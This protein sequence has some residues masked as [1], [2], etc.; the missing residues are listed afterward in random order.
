MA[1]A[2]DTLKPYQ[3]TIR[4]RISTALL[5]DAPASSVRG[6]FVKGLMGDTGLSA[7]GLG[8]VDLLPFLQAD[9]AG[10]QMA[11]K[12]QRAA[13]AG[14]LALSI[15][16]IPTVANKLVKPVAKKAAKGV[17][18]LIGDVVGEAAPSVSKIADAMEGAAPIKATTPLDAIMDRAK[19]QGVDLYVSQGNDGLRLSKIVVPKDQRGQGVG[20]AV[21]GDLLDYADTTGQRVTLTPSDAFGGSVPR[22]KKFYG[23]HDFTPNAGR[24]RD[25]STQDTMIRNP[26]PK[27]PIP[28][29][30]VQPKITAYH[31]SPHDFDQFSLDKVGTGEGAQAYGHGL[32]F[33]ENEAVA[34]GYRDQ[35]SGDGLVRP[36]GTVWKPSGLRHMNVRVEANRN[37]ADLDATI[38]KAQSLLPNAPPATRPLLE[39]DIAELMELR[40]S[41]GVKAN[42]GSMYQVGIDADPEHFL[43]W[44]K[45]L[46]EQSDAYRQRLDAALKHGDTSIDEIAGVARFDED[47]G[48]LTGETIYDSLGR[49]LESPEAATSA[50]QRGGI[51]GIKYL[52]QGSRNAGGWHITPPSETVSGKWMVKGSDYNSKGLQFDTE[53]EAKAALAEKIGGQTRNF[54]VFDEKLITILKKY[55]WVP[56]AALPAAAIA[57]YTKENGSPPPTVPMV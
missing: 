46:S 36:D 34:K 27:A 35:I 8:I 17:A 25:F 49:F 29:P 11:T 51:P 26:K 48:K 44:E 28:V 9:E 2:P 21:M 16:P 52:D 10:R 38:A 40:D 22:L 37:G 6:R 3:P 53:A 12:G 4:N 31:G 13:G 39:A 19:A 54:V 7:T 47:A 33:A 30:V 23:A 15:V 1:R 24:T 45:P 20:S 57:E 43:D 55:G 41:G 18:R 56:G 5:G 32:Y 42:P 14:N 50:L